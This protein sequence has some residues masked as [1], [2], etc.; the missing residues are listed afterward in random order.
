MERGCQE[1]IESVG[2]KGIQPYLQVWKIASED[3]SR[4]PKGEIKVN[5]VKHVVKG[6]W[7]LRNLCLAKNFNSL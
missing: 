4:R 6:T 7:V 1:H 5:T 2:N 3:F